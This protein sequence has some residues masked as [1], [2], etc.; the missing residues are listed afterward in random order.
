MF[1]GPE[2]T[3]KTLEPLMQQMVDI[4][5]DSMKVTINDDLT[6]K[7]LAVFI[8]ARNEKAQAISDAVDVIDDEDT[9]EDDTEIK[10]FLDEE[11]W[12][13]EDDDV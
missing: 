5:G 6:G 13:D 12:H 2:E 7:V 9:H 8:I 10:F 3:F 4:G 11:L 1:I